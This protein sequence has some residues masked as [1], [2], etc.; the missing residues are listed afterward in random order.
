MYHELVAKKN[1]AAVALGKR[2]ATLM[3]PEE[4][5]DLGVRAGLARAASLTPERRSEIARKAAKARWAK[6]KLLEE[7]QPSAD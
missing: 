1:A 7:G 4:H 6:K 3:T 2:R 5:R